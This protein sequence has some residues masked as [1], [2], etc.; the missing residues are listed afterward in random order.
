MKLSTLILSTLL[1]SASY[2][3]YIE[4]K[5]QIQLQPLEYAIKQISPPKVNFIMPKKTKQNYWYMDIIGDY[6]EFYRNFR[7][8]LV[9][10]HNR[11]KYSFDG[12]RMKIAYRFGE[13][14][15]LPKPSPPVV[16]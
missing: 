11:W 2:A 5:Q 16:E 1:S 9:Y 8:T 10:E 4:P 14:Y 15:A 13:S 7:R 6:D 3:Q 12:E